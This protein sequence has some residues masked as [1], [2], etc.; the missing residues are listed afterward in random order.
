MKSYGDDTYGEGIAEIYDQFYEQFDPA[1]IDLLFEFAAGGQALELGIG[2]GRIALPLV[3][4]GV[5]IQGIDASEAMLAKFRAKPSNADIEVTRSS[6]E[7]FQIAERFKL[8]YVV[9]NT[10]FALLSQ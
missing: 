2:T 5:K 8:I 3:A 1:C 7:D 9:F 4:K 6:F 10:F